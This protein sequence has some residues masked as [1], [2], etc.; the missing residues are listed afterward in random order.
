[1]IKTVDDA[2]KHLTETDTLDE[3]QVSPSMSNTKSENAPQSQTNGTTH[4]ATKQILLESLPLVLIVH[5]KRFLYDPSSNRTLK[6]RKAI[7][8]STSLHLPTS[9]LSPQISHADILYQLTAIIYHH[10][11]S[12]SGGHYTC[13]VR[14]SET[15]WLYMDDASCTPITVQQLNTKG[16]EYLLLYQRET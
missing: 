1:M 13:A 12:A 4:Q 8:Y 9:V 7:S 11:H 16:T 6:L 5:L 14:T 10:G 2:L 3:F 15:A